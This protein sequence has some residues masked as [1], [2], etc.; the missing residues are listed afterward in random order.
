MRL[1]IHGSEKPLHLQQFRPIMDVLDDDLESE[2][3]F[4]HSRTALKLHPSN[5]FFHRLRDFCWDRFGR[6]RNTWNTKEWYWIWKRPGEP[7]IRLEQPDPS[8]QVPAKPFRGKLP[9]RPDIVLG[10]TPHEGHMRYQL[11]PWANKSNIPVVS[12]DHG[13]PMVPYDFGV[14]RGSMMGCNANACWGQVAANI[15][16][17]YGAPRESQIVTGSPTIDE[18]ATLDEGTAFREKIGVGDEKIILLMTTHR[19]P[20]K[21]ITDQTHRDIIN[22]WGK[23][24][25]F[26]IIVKPHPVE[27]LDGTLMELEEDI[28]VMTE[29][30][31]LH[32]LIKA[33]HCIVSPASSILIPALA[34]ATPFVNLHQ[35]GCGLADESEIEI[36]Q[37]H[38]GGAD[39]HPDQLEQILNEEISA[40]KE[41][42][43]A[44]FTRLGHRADGHNAERILDLCGHVVSGEK[45]ASWT[46]PFN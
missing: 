17:G 21:S 44:A 7:P 28:I 5:A 9:F 39:F 24:P 43:E 6:A 19:E 12:I 1:L 41:K 2:Y 37:N 10:T 35:P 13:A 27:I 29:Q 3:I 15:N 20:L 33:A 14:Y 18:L 4:M 11:I 34:L 38:L 31:H 26:R 25:D 40:D 23:N 45:P 8:W 42:C 16:A 46:D 32:P 30:E 22:R 36:L